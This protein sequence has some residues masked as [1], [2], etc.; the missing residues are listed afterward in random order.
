MMELFHVNASGVILVMDSHV[1]ILTNVIFQCTTVTRMPHALILMVTSIV[2]VTLDLK[3]MVSSA[4]MSMSVPTKIMVVLNSHLA[5]IILDPL[6]A[7]VNLDSLVMDSPV[8][9]LMNVMILL[10]M[11]TLHVLTHLV[12][13]HAH[14]IPVSLV[15]ELIVLISTNVPMVVILVMRQLQLAGILSEHSNATVTVASKKLKGSVLMLMNVYQTLAQKMDH[16]I[17]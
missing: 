16:V 2:S 3:V 14:V 6:C 8:M 17:T 7:N 1:K 15:M 5:P 11:I 13:I 4:L 9:I 10:A 12:A